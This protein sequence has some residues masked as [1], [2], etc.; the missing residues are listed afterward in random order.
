MK[1]WMTDAL[2]DKT[3]KE[4]EQKRKNSRKRKLA[5]DA[6]KGHLVSGDLK[7]AIDV[8]EYHGIDATE[9]GKIVE[10]LRKDGFSV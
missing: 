6:I 8:A 2:L 9:F 4:T 5:V 7:R 3:S 10:Q 1:N